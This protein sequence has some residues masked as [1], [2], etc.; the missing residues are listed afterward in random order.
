[1]VIV[2]D[3][4]LSLAIGKKGQNARLAAKLTGMRIDIK[5]ES[6][7]RAERAGRRRGSRRAGQLPGVGPELVEALVHAGL[8]LAA[9][10][11]APG[12]SGWPSVAEVGDRADTIYAAAEEWWPPAPRTTGRG[13]EP[14]GP[15]PS[16]PTTDTR[17]PC[18]EPH[19]L[20]CRAVQPRTAPW[21]GWSGG[22]AGR[23]RRR[24]PPGRGAY[25]CPGARACE[26]ALNR[27]GWRRLQEAVC[28]R[29]VAVLARGGCFRAPGPGLAGQEVR[30][31]VAAAKIKVIELAKELG[32]TS[33]D[34]MVAAEEMGT[35]ASA[36]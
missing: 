26:Q 6:R 15:R 3:N 34:L 29:L 27:G 31:T 17:E 30:G 20:G 19:V 7:S 23:R 8:E 9:A 2:P 18:A 10:I 21:S 13:D 25:V 11:V 22:T 24:R 36:R 33:K 12:A 1:M 16:E 4:Q 28:G 32:V 14:G 35:R 5:S